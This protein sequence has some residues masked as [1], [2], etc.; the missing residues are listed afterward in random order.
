MQDL[1]IENTALKYRVNE[2]KK[3][4]KKIRQSIDNNVSHCLDFSGSDFDKV[5]SP[6]S[7]SNEIHAMILPDVSVP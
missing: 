3:E 6:V 7:N 2:L 4:L 5:A 1:T